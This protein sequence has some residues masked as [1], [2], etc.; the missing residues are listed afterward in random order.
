ME[1]IDPGLDQERPDA[2]PPTSGEVGK[3]LR[4][5]TDDEAALEALFYAEFEGLCEFVERYVHASAVAEELVQD[6]FL[7]V[8]RRRATC[9]LAAIHR[10]YLYAAARNS[11][12]QYVRHEKVDL[13]WRGREM[14]TK[15]KEVAEP[16]DRNLVMTE[17]E[18]AV[19]CAIA[20][21]PE[22]CRLVFTLSR[23]HGL[24]HSEIADILGISVGT[25]EVHM[26]R[27]LKALRTKLVPYLP[28]LVAAIGA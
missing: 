8:W 25:V 6:V 28:F 12:L 17:L 4:L 16:A 20:G 2:D 23:H 13:R 21:L 3:Q 18:T 26:H 22:R 10:S 24:H 1:R 7:R 11:A 19:E 14:T 27:A 15:V 9:S 5:V